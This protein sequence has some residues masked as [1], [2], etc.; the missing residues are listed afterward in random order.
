MALLGQGDE[1]QVDIPHEPGQHMRFR[2]L[3]G[4]DL[5]R[6]RDATSARLLKMLGSDGLRELQQD[7]R[8]AADEG[9]ADPAAALDVDTVLEAGIAG[10]TYSEAL[11]PANIAR[12]DEATR[13]WAFGEIVRISLR[14]AAAVGES[15]AA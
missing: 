14:T 9:E 11:M 5:Q 12:L 13:T 2:P 8:G 7:A 1:V 10:W 3:T 4:R 15:D 6:A